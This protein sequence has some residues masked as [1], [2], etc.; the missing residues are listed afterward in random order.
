MSQ[1][2]IKLNKV[3]IKL[4]PELEKLKY[5]K[6][7]TKFY[8]LE[9]ISA[10]RLTILRVCIEIGVSEDYFRKWTKRLLK[11]L[12]LSSLSERSRKLKSRQEDSSNVGLPTKV[13]SPRPV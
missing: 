4:S 12:K 2:K 13:P 8:H 5:L 7:R 3:L 10:P 9:L 11:T 6:A 1:L